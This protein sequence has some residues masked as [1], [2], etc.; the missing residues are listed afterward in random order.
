MRVTVDVSE[1]GGLSVGFFIVFDSSLLSR[2]VNTV[3]W[4]CA[5]AVVIVIRDYKHAFCVMMLLWAPG[6]AS[7]L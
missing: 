4:F 5:V 3:K 7:G 6:T 1:N 2:L